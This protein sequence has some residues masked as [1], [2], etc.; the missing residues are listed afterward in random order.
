MRV[1]ISGPITGVDDYLEKFNAAEEYLK[2]NG[3]EVINPA[4]L[5]SIMPETLDYSEY[6]RLDY[7][8]LDLCDA[9][10]LLK[11]WNISPGSKLELNHYLRRF[12]ANRIEYKDCVKIMIQE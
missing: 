3:H 2:S 9:I 5:N 10:Y 1:Y 8:Y 12:T 6:M 7:Q 11:D 4:K